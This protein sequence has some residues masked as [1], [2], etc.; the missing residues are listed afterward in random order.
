MTAEKKIREKWVLC[1]VD[2]HTRIPHGEPVGRCTALRRG[3]KEAAFVFGSAADENLLRQHE[4][5][6]RYPC[7]RASLIARGGALKVLSVAPQK[8]HRPQSCYT[9]DGNKTDR[10]GRRGGGELT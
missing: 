8:N 9:S 3:G 2:H 6:D 1:Q 7:E 10:S 5:M 4:I